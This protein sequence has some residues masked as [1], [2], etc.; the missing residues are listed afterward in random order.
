MRVA[1]RTYSRRIYSRRIVMFGILLLFCYRVLNFALREMTHSSVFSKKT[2]KATDV[3]HSAD[4]GFREVTPTRSE[5][6]VNFQDR[7]HESLSES[8]S[9][10]PNRTTRSTQPPT[11][12]GTI[13]LYSM[14]RR[15]RTGSA[16][17]DMLWAYA[18]ARQNNLPY[19]GTCGSSR[20]VDAH[21]RTLASLGWDRLFGVHDT[22]S[23]LP[24]STLN[25]E[26][27]REN[28]TKA[29]TLDFRH[30]MW[31][32]TLGLPNEDEATRNEST[33]HHIV[34]HIRRGD[35]HLCSESPTVRKRYIPNRY[36]EYVIDETRQVLT[37]N[38]TSTEVRVTIFS[39]RKSF[40]SWEE[41]KGYDLRLDGDDLASIWKTMANADALVLSKSSFSF[42][43]AL[44]N[45][46]TNAIVWYMPFRLKP[47]PE[48]KVLSP[49][50]MHLAESWADNLYETCNLT[51]PRG[52]LV[53]MGM[54]RQFA[55]E[56]YHR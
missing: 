46:K 26:V 19:K 2:E 12:D 40:E 38:D 23:C 35:V 54:K 48:W 39:E 47:M 45:V 29:F 53:D 7:D 22:V 15:D 13:A 1:R 24:G 17:L 44:L 51:E 30:H 16:I 56:A 28:N 50:L 37:Q 9:L 10:D 6:L 42:I 52:L 31:K 14:L 20:H 25:P 49:A 3:G 8:T 11:P 4:E 41:L 21:R 43:G 27:Y 55:L 5:L 36:Y 34:S 32:H 18:F 33:Y